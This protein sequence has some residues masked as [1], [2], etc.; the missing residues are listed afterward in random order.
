MIEIGSILGSR[1]TLGLHHFH[2]P[3][4]NRILLTVDYT[5]VS[6]I[7][8]IHARGEGC[9]VKV[10]YEQRSCRAKAETPHGIYHMYEA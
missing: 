3:G 4:A 7:N 9:L 5:K 10:T 8:M 2:L 1:N 6:K